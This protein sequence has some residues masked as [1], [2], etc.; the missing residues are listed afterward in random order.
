LRGE[1]ADP[2]KR[3]GQ[4]RLMRWGE[5]L[6]KD[7]VFREVMRTRKGKGGQ[8]FHTRGGNTAGRGKNEE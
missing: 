3:T 1:T 7:E 6:K 4:E 5:V 8:K 2:K